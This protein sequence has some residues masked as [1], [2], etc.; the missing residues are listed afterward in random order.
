MRAVLPAAHPMP[1]G[2]R[3]GRDRIPGPARVPD[4]IRRP[5]PARDLTRLVLAL[6]L[7]L[8]RGL[9]RRDRPPD[10]GRGRDLIPPA[11]TAAPSLL[12]GRGLV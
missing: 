12:L 4:R 3:R 11:A 1:A 9:T 6:V 8:A 5:T 2:N 7:V 10:P